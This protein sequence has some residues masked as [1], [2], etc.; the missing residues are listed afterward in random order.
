MMNICVYGASSQTLDK[1][2]I[3]AGESLG[4]AIA[5][6]HHT[7]IFGG[8]TNGMMGAAARG[9]KEKGGFVVGIAPTFFEVDGVL[10]DKCDRL[11]RPES[12]RE[13]K[14][15]LEELSDAFVMMVGGIGTFDEFF[16][17]LTL[18]ELGRH[19][20]PIVILNT[21]HFFDPL[22]AVIDHGVSTNSIG[23]RVYEMFRVFEDPEEA[24]NY[25]DGFEGREQTL[26]IYKNII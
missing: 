22:L 17:I 26:Q 4:R 7:L 25:I 15:M 20:C 5:S 6:H 18:K 10:Y 16:E 1:K 11:L 13:R 3:E 12:M 14:L 9:A 23:K 19:G 24:L 8:G 2:Y 21:D